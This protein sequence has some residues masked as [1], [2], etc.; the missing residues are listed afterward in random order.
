MREFDLVPASYR[1]ALTQRRQVRGYLGAAAVLLVV[2]LGSAGTLRYLGQQAEAQVTVL[3]ARKAISSRQRDM[4]AQLRAEQA[5]VA[6]ELAVLEGLRGGVSTERIFLAMDRALS[7]DDLWFS[8][9]TFQRAGSQIPVQPETV[10]TGYFIVVPRDAPTGAPQGWR[11][12][13]HLTIQGH[14]LDHAALSGFVQRLQAQDEISSV[15]ILSTQARAY[16]QMTVVDF[17]LAVQVSMRAG[18]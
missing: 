16:T 15:R 14:A 6:E 2:G 1:Q 7:G 11:I 10:N 12:Q 8:R 4:L 9:T 18:A 3:E 13:T 5:Q 17:E